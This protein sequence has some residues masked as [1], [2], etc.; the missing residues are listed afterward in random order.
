MRRGIARKVL[1]SK[2]KSRHVARGRAP[3]SKGRAGTFYQKI[4][5]RKGKGKVCVIRKVGGIGDVLMVTPALRQLR[6][7]FRDLDITFA[8]DMHTTANNVYYELVRNAPF[9]TRLIDARY[10]KHGEYD[11]VVDVSSVCLRYE[12]EGLPAINRIDLFGRAMGIPILQDKRSWYKVE[13]SETEWAARVLDKRAG[14]KIVVLHTASM[15]AKR[16]WPIE[17]YLAIVKQAEI[18]ELPVHFVILDFNNKYA[19]WS[20]HS[21]CSNWS[22]T[23]LREMAALIH[24]ADLFIGPDSGPMHLA[25]AVSTRSIVLF[26]SIPP[27]ARI[28]HYPTHEAVVKNGMGCLGCWYKACPFDTKCM[29][30]LDA[31]IVYSRMKER[32][33]PM[34]LEQLEL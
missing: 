8:I 26:G 23:N 6:R 27:Q 32:L 24:T 21:N 20:K 14:K 31:M 4:L 12:R 10:V 2:T 34:H 3:V 7:D 17:K 11:A 19:H 30:D 33:W 22:Q 28:N 1:L 5:A 16:C 25:G 15:E 29:K 13:P 18:D 9:V